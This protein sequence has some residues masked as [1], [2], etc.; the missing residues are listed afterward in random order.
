MKHIEVTDMSKT[1]KWRVGAAAATLGLVA[2]AGGSSIARA[3]DSHMN[4]HEKAV[5]VTVEE[6]DTNWD[7][8]NDLRKRGAQESTTELIEELN[9]AEPG[10]DNAIMPGEEV[11]VTISVPDQKQ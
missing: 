8:A 3:H 1:E 2:V 6:G 9:D 5:T 11:E 7:L 10:P 4:T